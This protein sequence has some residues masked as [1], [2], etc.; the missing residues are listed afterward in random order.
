MREGLPAA[1]ATAPAATTATAPAATATALSAA[2]AATTKATTAATAAAAEAAATAAAAA[3]TKAAAALSLACDVYG[4]RAAVDHGSVQ[5]VDGLLRRVRACKLDEPEASTLTGHAVE[6]DG[7]RNQ[8]AEL[9]EGVA[10]LVLA[11]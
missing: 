3:A 8:L 1:A 2:T 6:Y 11:R 7:N 4:D 5:V 10:E 9:R